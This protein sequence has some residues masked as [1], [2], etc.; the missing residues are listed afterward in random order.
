MLFNSLQF[1]LFFLMVCPLYYL[2]PLTGRWI[3]LLLASCYFY[4][5]LNPYYLS[6]LALAIGVDY[7]C[8]LGLYFTHRTTI[9]RGILVVSI[10]SNLVILGY[11]KY[12]NFFLDNLK[13]VPGFSEH[14]STFLSIALPIGLSFHTFQSM[15]YC[16]EVY[17][18]KTLFEKNPLVFSLF[19][20]FFPQLVAGPIERPTR[21]L[22]QLHVQQVFN[23]EQV[24]SG[25]LLLAWGLFKKAVLSDRLAPYVDLIFDHP[26]HYA[27]GALLL[28]A[29]FFSFQIYCDFSGYSDMAR[30]IARVMGYDLMVNFNMPYFA[31]NIQEFWTRWHISLSSWFRDYVY[32]PLGGSKVSKTMHIRNILLVFLLSG[33]WHG[34]NWTFLVWGALHGAALIGFLYMPRRTGWSIGSVPAMLLTF[35]LVT[36][37]WIFFRAPTVTDAC[38]YISQMVEMHSG[39]WTS[40]LYGFGHILLSILLIAGLLGMERWAFPKLLSTKYFYLKALAFLAVLYLLGVYQQS[41]FIYFQF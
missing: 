13:L 4:A 24:R 19:V 41:Q 40:P 5:V 21:L 11:F 7:F 27:S 37:C 30:G 18:D 29:V 15:S 8:G 22:Q 35:A 10:L 2:L 38:H 14:T 3:L 12:Y 1:L 20:M 28:A 26:G 6:I 34:A 31:K 33:M 32:I 9:R 16:I 39:S 36:F 25:L 23:P 17:R